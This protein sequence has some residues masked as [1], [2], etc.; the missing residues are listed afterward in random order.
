[1]G[2]K[3]L[4]TVGERPTDNGILTDI[5]YRSTLHYMKK[6]HHKT[7]LRLLILAILLVSS[8]CASHSSLQDLRRSYLPTRLG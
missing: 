1:M 4:I 7:F 3:I 8:G 6:K 5:P 2:L